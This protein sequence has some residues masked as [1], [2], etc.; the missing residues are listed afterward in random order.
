MLGGAFRRPRPGGAD[1]AAAHAQLLVEQGTT[2]TNFFVHT[3]ICNPSRSE[4]LTGRLFHNLKRV[5]GAASAMHVDEAR[6]AQLHVRALR[7]ER[8]GY[9]TGLFGKY[10]NAM[11]ASAPPGFDA[12]LANAGGDYVAPKFETAGSRTRAPADGGWNGT[13][14]NYSTAV[15]GN[16]SIAWIERAVAGA[17]AADP[18]EQRAAR[19]PFFAY[20][21]PK[22]AATSRS[23]RRRG[24]PTRGTTRGPRASRARRRGT[25]ARPR[26]RARAGAAALARRSPTTRPP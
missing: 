22:A 3:P 18:A 2:F 5:G 9:A 10:L 23:T 17:D 19:R 25:R 4:L 13:V 7:R 6:R 24:T 11:P 14:D 26:A 15:I 21:A 8:G 12:W 16:C 20:V 1:V